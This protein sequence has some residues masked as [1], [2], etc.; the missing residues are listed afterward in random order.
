MD[1]GIDVGHREG[2][3]IAQNRLPLGG[4]KR[5]AKSESAQ[6]LNIGLDTTRTRRNENTNRFAAS[7]DHARSGFWEITKNLRRVL[8]KLAGIQKNRTHESNV[9]HLGDTVKNASENKGLVGTLMPT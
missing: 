6:Q 2:G 8:R 4:C 3:R 5:L 7:C 9:R 1:F